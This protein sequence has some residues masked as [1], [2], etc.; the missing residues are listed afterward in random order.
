MPAWALRILAIAISGLTM[1]GSSS[2]VLA[3]PFNS[4]APLRPP[5]A[6]DPE[7]RATLQPTPTP[8]PSPTP[9]QTPSPT[10]TKT[11][12]PTKTALA[13]AKATATVVPTVRTATPAPRTPVPTPRPTLVLNSG[14]K[15]TAVPKVTLT[16]SS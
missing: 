16:H 14:V 13:V 5:V 11:A 3:H 10:P 8:T 15:M 9:S 7:A 4:A 1:L 6:K 2:Y 12:A